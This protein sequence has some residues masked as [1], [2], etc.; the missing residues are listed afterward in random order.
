VIKYRLGCA[1]A[2][3]FESW[4]RAIDDY[5]AQM[6]DGA[7]ACPLCGLTQIDKLPMAPA[8]VGSRRAES[9]RE[10]EQAPMQTGSGS[11]AGTGGA[12]PT[13]NMLRML[14]QKIIENSE[15]VGTR[16]AE[17]ARKM[18]FGEI[19]ERQIRG[20]STAE[21]AKG[22]IEDGIDFGLMPNLP[23]DLN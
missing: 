18:H 3:E 9:R 20:S 5:D 13:L 6:R 2:H 8:V 17:E 23:E 14:K 21:E 22:L 11:A 15:D 12:A 19:E 1:N 7:I 16:F 10:S 4:F